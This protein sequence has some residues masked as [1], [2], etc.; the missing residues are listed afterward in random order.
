MAGAIATM[1]GT[2]GMEAVMGTRT[3]TIR[4]IWEIIRE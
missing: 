4:G 3:V 1:M 2:T